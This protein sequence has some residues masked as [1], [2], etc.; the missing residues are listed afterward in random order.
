[1]IMGQGFFSANASE[2]LALI[3]EAKGLPEDE[4]RSLAQRLIKDKPAVLDTM[5]REELGNNPEEMGGS[6]WGASG[7][8][9]CLF[10]IGAIVQLSPFFSF[11]EL[12]EWW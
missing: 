3:Y 6:A 10:A 12:R 2:E 9:F 4:A 11:P 8:S 7:A 1:M 5:A